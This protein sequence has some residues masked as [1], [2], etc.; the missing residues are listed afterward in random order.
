MKVYTDGA[1]NMGWGGAGF[2]VTL[3]GRQ[4]AQ[5]GRTLKPPTTNNRA[6]V[7]AVICACEWLL[8]MEYSRCEIITDSVYVMNCWNKAGKW[9]RA[10]WRN[11]SGVVK[12]SDLLEELLAVQAKLADKSVLVTVTWVKGHAGDKFNEV[13]DDYAG[14]L[15]RCRPR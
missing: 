5:G 1:M 14:F 9:K 4:V 13:A 15:A 3:S 7:Q 10:G 2:I 11:T 12:N 6:E 8:D